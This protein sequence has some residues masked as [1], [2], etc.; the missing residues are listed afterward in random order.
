MLKSLQNSQYKLCTL[1]IKYSHD[2]YELHVCAFKHSKNVWH[3]SEFVKITV[4][5]KDDNRTQEYKSNERAKETFA[6]YVHSK[7]GSST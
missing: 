5:N 6:V 3:T 2:S 4:G 7:D 1:L